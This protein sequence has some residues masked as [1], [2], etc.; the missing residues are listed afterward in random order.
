MRTSKPLSTAGQAVPVLAVALL[1]SGCGDKGGTTGPD[2][3]AVTEV[4]VS[5][6]GATEIP[7]G[8]QVQLHASA[9]NS[10][11]ETIPGQTIQWRSL[12]EAVVTVDASGLARG[13]GEGT[14]EITASTAGRLG[15]IAVTVE[16]LAPP[17][18]PSALA[19]AAASHDRIELS[20]SDNSADETHFQLERA[21]FVPGAQGEGE[22]GSFAELAFVAA[23][24]TTF[25]DGGLEPSSLYRYRVRACRG[26][27][28]SGYTPPVDASTGGALTVTTVELSGG[29]VGLPY[30]AALA[31]Q[32]GIGAL[33]WEI[34]SGVL[35]VGVSLASAG[36]LSG[37]PSEAGLFEFTARVRSADGQSASKALSLTVTAPLAIATAALPEGRIGEAYLASLSVTGG[38]PPYVWSLASGTLPAGLALDGA[39]GRIQG[40]PAAA[41]TFLLDLRVQDGGGQLAQRALTLSVPAA[42]VE[43]ITTALPSGSVGAPYSQTLAANGGGGAERVWSLASGALPPGLTLQAQTGTISGTPTTAGSQAFTVRV[44]AGGESDEQ[45]LSIEVQAPAGGPVTIESWYLPVGYVG[46]AYQ[47]EVDVAGGGEGLGFQVIAGSLPPGLSIDGSGTIVGTPG[48]AGTAHFTLRVSSGGFEATRTF[49]LSISSAPSGG[50]NIAIVNAA[51]ILPSGAVQGSLDEAVAKWE[52]AI[53]SDVSSYAVPAFGLLGSCQG[54]AS[55]LRPGEVIEDLVVLLDVAPID[56]PSGTL[57]QAGPCGLL[58]GTPALPRTGSVRMDSADLAALGGE[59]LTGTILHEIGHVIGIGTIWDSSPRNLVSGEGGSNPRFVGLQGIA[60]YHALGGQDADI[61]VETNQYG[62]GT[63]DA[64]WRESTFDREVMT[65]F[66]ESGSFMP[67]SRMTIGALGDLGYGVNLGAADGFAVSAPGAPGAAAEPGIQI[68]LHDI[69]TEPLYV[70]GADGTI[71]QI[72]PR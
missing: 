8:G 39:Q 70:Q 10:F 61:A 44:V 18:A 33:T 51:G 24:V 60:A 2:P 15:E 20:W 54:H 45:S 19:G 30:E 35:P 49:A 7:V 50:F 36:D 57:A 72:L 32:G 53:T 22:A 71:H 66:I 12:N 47:G 38:V 64:H 37:I 25:V 40:T 1:L 62:P 3:F 13:L 68:P 6:S 48:A 9:R 67:L 28:C 14:T 69:A 58:V 29:L 46:A 42:S 34:A 52:A 21:V 5:A 16:A 63:A 17:P 43:I 56:G 31:A 27:V 65:G 11:G 59:T 23:D 41:G 26:S 4:V 55:K